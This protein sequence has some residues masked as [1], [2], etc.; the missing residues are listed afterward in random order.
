M[1][2]IKP[3]WR[4]ELVW[5][6]SQRIAAQMEIGCGG[7]IGG[8]MVHHRRTLINE[9]TLTASRTNSARSF[10]V[11]RPRTGSNQQPFLSATRN[12]GTLWFFSRPLSL[13]LC[14]W[15]F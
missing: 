7:A 10:M 4:L 13:P 5:I 6:I 3:A 2:H 14:A 11:Q 12:W 9:R 1:I 8:W 15:V